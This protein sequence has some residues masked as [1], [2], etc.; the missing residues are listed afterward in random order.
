LLTIPGG[1]HGG[2]TPEERT[3]IYVTIREFLAANGIIPK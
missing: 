1:K 3:T 2:F